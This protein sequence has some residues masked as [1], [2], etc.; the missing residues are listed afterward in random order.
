VREGLRIAK[1]A[2]PLL[3]LAH[4]RGVHRKVDHCPERTHTIVG[5]DGVSLEGWPSNGVG[6]NARRE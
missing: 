5:P 6:T 3:E 2:T 1:R 4:D